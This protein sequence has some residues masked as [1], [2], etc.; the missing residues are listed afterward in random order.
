MKLMHN[1]QVDELCLPS[2]KIFDFVKR[3]SDEV[4]DIDGPDH[5]GDYRENMIKLWEHES[6]RISMRCA[7]EPRHEN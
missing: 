1:K 7:R 2:Q 5:R 4:R 3:G 6:S